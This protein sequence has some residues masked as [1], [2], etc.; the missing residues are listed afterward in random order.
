MYAGYL[1]IP[2]AATETTA[3]TTTTTTTTAGKTTVNGLFSEK[4]A[5]T[6]HSVAPNSKV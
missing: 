3:S 2:S 4:E 6:T 1:S 5:N